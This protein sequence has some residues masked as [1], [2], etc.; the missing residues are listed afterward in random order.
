[1]PNFIFLDTNIF[2]HYQDFDRIDWLKILGIDAGKIVIP[3]VTV[4][5][6]NKQ[7]DTSSRKRIRNRAATTLRKLF[8]WF[9]E[10]RIVSIAEGLDVVFEDRDPLID[11]ERFQV[12][13]EVQDDHLIASALMYQKETADAVVTLVTSDAG[14]TLI[15]KA[16]RLR[17]NAKKL[18]DR[19]KLPLEPDPDQQR[20]KEL[21]Q[22]LRALKLT[23]PRLSLTF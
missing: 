8:D 14:L 12:S 5:E 22:E 4:R 15:A 1:V 19:F 6:L 9:E 21:E 17:I 16:N 11:F 2:L 3:P 7:K 13:R 20:I 23:Q 10:N 18:D